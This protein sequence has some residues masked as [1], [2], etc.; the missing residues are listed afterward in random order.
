MFDV[1]DHRS[2]MT[3]LPIIVDTTNAD[4]TSI[5]NPNNQI[6]WVLIV[7]ANLPGLDYRATFPM[8]VFKLR[9]APR[10]SP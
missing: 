2:R 4:E 10:L 7:E 8:P 3:S 1:A 5:T 9:N 6:V